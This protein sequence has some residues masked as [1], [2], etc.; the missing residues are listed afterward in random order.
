[1]A[2]WG[3]DPQ[4]KAWM[5]EHAEEVERIEKLYNLLKDMT[6]EELTELAYEVMVDVAKHRAQFRDRLITD[7]VKTAPEKALAI[8][9]GQSVLVS[10]KQKEAV[11]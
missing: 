8:A 5:K 7:I 6:L 11:K 2:R 9:S 4:V 10:D 3:S 1:M